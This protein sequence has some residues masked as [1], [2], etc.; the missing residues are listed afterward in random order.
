[1]I[2]ICVWGGI[3]LLEDLHNGDPDPQKGGGVFNG[4]PQSSIRF[5]MVSLR[6]PKKR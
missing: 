1:M 6:L 5:A 4:Y 2:G 3:L